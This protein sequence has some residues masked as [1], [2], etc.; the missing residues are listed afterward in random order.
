MQLWPFS[1]TFDQ[2]LGVIVVDW[3]FLAVLT[4][5]LPSLAVPVKSSH[6]LADFVSE[7]HQRLPIK[8]HQIKELARGTAEGQA[9][10]RFQC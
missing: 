4:G 3:S 9:H 8:S 10:P 2:G 5:L 6:L 7:I 1:T